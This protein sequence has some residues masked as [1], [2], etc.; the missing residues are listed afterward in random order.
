M[1]TDNT[2]MIEGGRLIF[3]NF[4]GKEGQYNPA[5]ARSFGV[6]LPEE[7]ATQMLED[8]WNVKYLPPREDAEEETETP[9][10]PVAVKYDG[11][12]PPKIV[13]ITARGRT[14]LGENEVAMLDWA[15]IAI[16]EQTGLQK[17]DLI[18]RPYTWDVSGRQG[19][20]AY[21]QS[22]YI[23]IEEDPLERKYAEMDA[24]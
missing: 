23:T 5:G 8:G 4:E 22:M 17:V 20:K 7:I 19:I 3:R 16:D 6:I 15:D 14:N 12:K 18:V 10:L 9:W 21:L 1:P 2:V 13:L 24:Q 11:G